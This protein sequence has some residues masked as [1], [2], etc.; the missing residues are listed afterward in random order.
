LKTEKYNWLIFTHPIEKYDKNGF[1]FSLL[2]IIYIQLWKFTPNGYFK[3]I[4][5]DVK[6]ITVVII[7]PMIYYF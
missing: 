7:S 5:M 1:S 3:F 6:T 4:G 2:V